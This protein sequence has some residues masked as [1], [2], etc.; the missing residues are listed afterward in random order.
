MAGYFERGNVFFNENERNSTD[1]IL[2]QD[3]LLAF[4][5]GSGAND[6]ALQ[7]A[8]AHLNKIAFVEKFNPKITKRK[9]LL[10]KL[11]NRF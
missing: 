6:D 1:F 5:K 9:S 2:L 10:S 11:K 7:S 4:E 8:I 3:Q